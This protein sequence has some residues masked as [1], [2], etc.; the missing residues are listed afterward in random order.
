MGLLKEQGQIILKPLNNYSIETA[1]KRKLA[2]ISI[3]RIVPL[4]I[5][6]YKVLKFF[7]MS[8]VLPIYSCYDF[9]FW[10]RVSCH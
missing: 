8:P 1:L 2:V 4:K 3:K 10:R 6:L 5:Y 7:L 9:S